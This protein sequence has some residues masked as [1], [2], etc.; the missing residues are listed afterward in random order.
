MIKAVI[1]DF[2]GT[3][4]NT[5]P[6]ILTCVNKT[7]RVYGFPERTEEEALSFINNGARELIRCAL[8]SAFQQDAATIDSVLSTYTQIY[9]EN[10]R[11]TRDTYDGILPLLAALRPT[12]RIGVL[13]NKQDAILKPLCAHVLPVGSYDTAQGVIPGKPTKPDPYLTNLVADTLGVSPSECAMVGDSD[14]DLRTALAAGMLPISVSWGYRSEAFL[15]S[16]G[17]VNI[18]RTPAEILEFL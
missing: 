14:V 6:A 1:F 17:A 15:R 4:A 13:S 10:Y 8:P 2:D 12:Y 7:L 16:A 18:A 5:I 11:L 3:L 9:L